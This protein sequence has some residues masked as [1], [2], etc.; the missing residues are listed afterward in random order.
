MCAARESPGSLES[1]LFYMRSF[2]VVSSMANTL[3]LAMLFS[4]N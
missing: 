4:I 2:L 1:G 3:G